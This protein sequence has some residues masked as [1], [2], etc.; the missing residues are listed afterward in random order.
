MVLHCTEPFII[1]LLSSRYDLMLKGTLIQKLKSEF[2]YLCNLGIWC[3][4][5]FFIL[6]HPKILQRGNEALDQTIKCIILLGWEISLALSTGMI[7]PCTVLQVGILT[8]SPPCGGRFIPCEGKDPITEIKLILRGLSWSPVKN[9]QILLRRRAK[10]VLW[11]IS[12]EEQSL[13]R[14]I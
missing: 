8:G 3:L 12:D 14:N 2:R 6:F 1:I 7:M 9:S 4:L 11:L 5:G 10:N 13:G